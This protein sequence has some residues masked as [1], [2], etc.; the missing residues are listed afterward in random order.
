VTD[1]LFPAV[2]MNLRAESGVHARGQG[3]ES[4]ALK[5]GGRVEPDEVL[6]LVQ[7]APERPAGFRAS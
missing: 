6:G 7:K 3:F 2:S 4:R 1:H 5:L